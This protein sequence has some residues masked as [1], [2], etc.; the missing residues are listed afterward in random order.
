MASGRGAGFEGLSSLLGAGYWE[1]DHTPVSIC[2]QHKLT[3]MGRKGIQSC[4]GRKVGW[5]W[6]ELLEG[7][8]QSEYIA[9][10]KKSLF[11]IKEK[12]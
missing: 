10:Q 5:I 1:F 8:L 7:K 4:V 9:C 6:E 3:L 12:F 2:G 11:R